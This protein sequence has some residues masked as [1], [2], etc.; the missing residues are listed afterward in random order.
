MFDVMAG[1]L[2]PFCHHKG[3]PPEYEANLQRKPKAKVIVTK[4]E[5]EF[6]VKPALKTAL[7]LKVSYKH[8]IHHSLESPKFILPKNHVQR[9][10]VPQFTHLKC[11][12]C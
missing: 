7:P 11:W 3:Q 8:N 4:K 9:V 6:S 5:Q 10:G 2:Q 12:V 1:M